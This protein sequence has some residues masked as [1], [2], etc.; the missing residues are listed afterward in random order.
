M[1]TDE[2]FEEIRDRNEKVQEVLWVFEG[3][4]DSVSA[5]YGLIE[6]V[7]RLLSEIERLKKEKE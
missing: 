7:P 1:I 5:L 3:D 4:E 2:E 6:D